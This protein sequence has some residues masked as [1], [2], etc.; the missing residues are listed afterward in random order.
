VIADARWKPNAQVDKNLVASLR[1][2]EQRASAPAGT[3]Y[4]PL[5]RFLITSALHASIMEFFSIL[6][7]KKIL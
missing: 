1:Y 2:Q 3:G 4:P 7:R 6:V 5:A